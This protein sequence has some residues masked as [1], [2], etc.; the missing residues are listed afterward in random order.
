MT[1]IEQR[2]KKIK[3]E[4]RDAKQTDYYST[5]EDFVFHKLAELELRIEQLEQPLKHVVDQYEKHH[6]NQYPIGST[7]G[8]P[9]K[10]T[11]PS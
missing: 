10:T 4:Y 1:P 8:S 9:I 3:K 11:N 7:T 6:T 5:T 2:A